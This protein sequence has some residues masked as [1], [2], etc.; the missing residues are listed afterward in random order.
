MMTNF[1]RILNEMTSYQANKNQIIQNLVDYPLLI[2]DDL[3]IERNSEFAL[4]NLS[5]A[6]RNERLK[7]S[8][9]ESGAKGAITLHNKSCKC[10]FVS[11]RDISIPQAELEIDMIDRTFLDVDSA[12]RKVALLKDMV[13]M[14]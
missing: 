9:C 13:C 3:G 8:I 11:A 1:S 7:K 4:V 5:Q 14:E 6:T 10:D 12:Q 2:I